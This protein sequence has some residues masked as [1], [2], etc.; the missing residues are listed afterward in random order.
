MRF[1][2]VLWLLLIFLCAAGIFSHLD[3]T[4]AL[5][6]CIEDVSGKCGNIFNYAISLE[7]EN[8]RLNKLYKECK[9]SNGL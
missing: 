8:A 3:K 9:A 6:Q 7:E 1:S 2:S 4:E 5:E